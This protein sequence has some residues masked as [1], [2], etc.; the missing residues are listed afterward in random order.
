MST[1]N[2]GSIAA[3]EAGAW[4]SM[5]SESETESLVVDHPYA[6]GFVPGMIRLV[7]SHPKIGPLFAQM[8]GQIM[9]S[10]DGE[11]DRREREMVATAA[12]VA[13]DCFY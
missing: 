1:A 2:K 8:Y 7:F 5:P 12:T 10:E 6:R 3:A 13:Q 11:L 4:V 9:F